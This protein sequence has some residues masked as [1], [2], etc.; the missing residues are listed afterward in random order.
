MIVLMI[1]LISCFVHNNED[2]KTNGN[3]GVI[4]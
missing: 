3:F 1:V 4:K 2:R